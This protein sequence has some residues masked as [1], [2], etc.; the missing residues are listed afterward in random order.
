MYYDQ[1][2]YSDQSQPYYDSAVYQPEGYDDRSHYADQSDNSIVVQA[3]E[4]LAREGFYHGE[5]DGALGPDMRHAVRR[6]QSSHGLRVT[7]YLDKETVTA[8]GLR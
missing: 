3:Q 2:N 6:Y 1:N 7:G 8:M 5:T 4:R